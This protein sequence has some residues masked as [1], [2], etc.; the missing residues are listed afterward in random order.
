MEKIPGDVRKTS[1]ERLTQRLR[2]A[3]FGE[4][5]LTGM[6]REQLMQEVAKLTTAS[7]ADVT[8][9]T[10]ERESMAT[11]G[12]D[13]TVTETDRSAGTAEPCRLVVC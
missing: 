8:P 11:G 6:T 10:Q 5:Q 1:T 13:E 12:Y 2:Q 3:G 7:T 4:T 9:S